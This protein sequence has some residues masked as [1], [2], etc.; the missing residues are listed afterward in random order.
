[1]SL[2]ATIANVD[3]LLAEVSAISMPPWAEVAKVAA[4]KLIEAR[5]TQDGRSSY[6][7]GAR[8]VSFTADGW[9]RF[10]EFAQKQ[11]GIQSSGGVGQQDIYFRQGAC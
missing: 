5:D 7:F 4:F 2:S 10:L 9:E 11:A 3:A 1:M 6:T 8:S